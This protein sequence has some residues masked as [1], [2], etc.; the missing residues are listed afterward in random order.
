MRQKFSK[1]V[2]PMA[3]VA[4]LAFGALGLAPPNVG[5][6]PG[7]PGPNGAND[8]GL[9]TAYFAGSEEGKENK[10]QA[11]PFQAL[12]QAAGD[13]VEDFCDNVDHPGENGNGNPG[14]GGGRP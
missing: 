5:D 1:S 9:C 7:N 10:R 11:P 6:I 13:S 8:F 4:V 12:E 14:N 2:L 3:A